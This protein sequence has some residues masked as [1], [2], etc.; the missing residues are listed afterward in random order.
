MSSLL[1]SRCWRL[2]LIEP[3]FVLVDRL[4]VSADARARIVDAAEIGFRGMGE[5]IF[6]T[7]ARDAEDAAEGVAPQDAVFAA[8]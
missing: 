8:V 7:A 3:V 4:V 6:E 2:I 5:V 1:R